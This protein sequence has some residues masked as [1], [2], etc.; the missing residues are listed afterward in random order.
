[1]SF[2]PGFRSDL[3]LS[4]RRLLEA[5]AFTLVCVVT[6][7]LGIGGNTAVFTLI[8]RVVLKPLPVQRPEEL[9][10]LGNTDDCCVNSGLA[11]SFSLFSY[12]LYTHLREAAP[13]FVHLA[14][15]QANT[16]A[17]TIGRVDASAPPETMNSAFVSGNYFQMFELVPAAGRLLQPSDDRRGAPPVAVISYRAWAE[18]FARRTDI[19]G[20]PVLLN[21]MTA[22][23]AGV[24]PQGFYG[25]TLRPNPAEIWIPLS[26]EP[27]LQPAARLLD[28]KPSHWLYIIGRLKP[29]AD[30]APLQAQ[31]TV[32]LQHWLSS[33]LDLSAEERNQVP[34]QHINVIPAAAGVSNLR[35]EV[36]PAL[37][38]LQALAAAVLLVACASLANLLLARGLAR[39]LETAV[40]VALG[41]SRTRLTAQFLLESTLLACAGGLAG[42]LVAV[43]GARA[44]IDLAFR[45]ATHV[46]VDPA[47]SLV[48]V[49]FAFGVSLV[50]GVVFGTAPAIVGS[51]S[52]PI[53]AMRGAGRATGEHGAGLRRSLI[54]LQV[55][56]SL[57]LITCAGLL[58]RSLRNLEAQD[59]GFRTDNRY[60]VTLAPS[61]ATTP[62]R[63]L[64]E[65]YARMQERLRRIPGVVNAAH[66]L[67]SPMSGDNWASLITVDG[68]GESERLVA[69]WNRVS[70]RYF[71]TVG[72]PL[73]RGRAVDERDGPES[74]LVA[75][76]SLAFAR[77]FFG[78]SDPIG[79]RIGFANSKGEGAREVEIVGITGDAKYQDGRR[80]PYVTFFLPFLQQTAASRARAAAAGVEIDRSHYPQAIEIH[81]A[82][83]VQGLEAEIRRALAEVD[84]RITVRTVI[85]IEEQVA[86][87][88]N[89][90]RLIARLT[91]AFG[92]VALLL[93]CLALYGI[94]AYSVSRR[95]REIGIRIAVG[96]SGARVLRTV[97]RGALGQVAVGFAAG[98]PAAFAAGRLLQAQLFGV[99]GHDPLVLAGG[100]LLLALSAVMAAALPARRAAATDPV[101]ALRVE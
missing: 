4:L 66:S 25:D 26:S 48:A 45:G 35:D 42:L 43:G 9:Y 22:T 67:Y 54:A 7:A 36:A 16:R 86:R 51:R 73:I 82:G 8:D 34:K 62:A 55:A 13:Q 41:A 75:V 72:T 6:L 23:I 21:G 74:P 100:S 59:F 91:V 65:I 90:E 37:Q 1:M 81:A 52:D 14:A 89:T 11:G 3:S 53:D 31:L 24:A 60:V 18:R 88:F 29:G 30:T 80:P 79:R 19:A 57:L 78:D 92:L 64:P 63:E 10:R 47:P 87:A 33:T 2:W 50:T 69:S 46:P 15:F 98:I 58:G 61:L 96:A 12:D 40:R 28:A 5:P 97:L 76:V 44:I 101:R 20:H 99:S 27:Q 49:A 83:P 95:T 17:V 84:R 70:P 38:L 77:K 93:A 39:R 68:H 71:E 56:L 85:P 32:Q 94:T